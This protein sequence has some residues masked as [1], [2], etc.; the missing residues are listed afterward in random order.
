MTGRPISEPNPAPN[1]G[2]EI[3]AKYRLTRLLGQ[4]SFG[5]VFEA[6]HLL[7]GRKAALRFLHGQLRSE[8]FERR[9]LEQIRAVGAVGQ[10]NIV[11]LLDVGQNASFGPFAAMELIE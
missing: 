2:L 9:F 7:A 10:E 4:G 5:T 6:E 1:V 3:D 8:A 11:E